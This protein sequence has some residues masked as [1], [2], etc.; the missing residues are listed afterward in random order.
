ML[1]NIVT[2]SIVIQLAGGECVVIAQIV[3]I[4][5]RTSEKTFGTNS[6]WL[7]LEAADRLFSVSVDGTC[8]CKV[9]TVFL[10]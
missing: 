4:V 1:L 10:F 5:Y 7:F 3:V 8:K 9:K 2:H 6:G